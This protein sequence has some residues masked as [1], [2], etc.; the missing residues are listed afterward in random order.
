M[1]K[2][3][4]DY[5]GQVFEKFREKYPNQEILFNQ[6]IV[7]RYSLVERQIDILIKASI[8][9]SVQIGVFDCKKFNKKIDVKTVDSMIG[10]MDDLNA[11]YG[12]I[13][14][15]RGFSKAAINRAR[16]GNI[17]LEVIEFKSVSELIDHFVP[18][19]DF[20]DARNSM[21]IALF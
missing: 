12:G 7:G 16:A 14:T 5:E 10:Y 19:L 15:C 4:R 11:N 17:K 6:N 13:I 3:W 18:S 9:D 20:S 1:N 8:A 2:S 21:Y